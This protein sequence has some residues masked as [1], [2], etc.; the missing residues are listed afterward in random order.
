MRANLGPRGPPRSNSCAKLGTPG[1]ALVV[2]DASAAIEIVL[3][4]PLAGPLLERI[5]AEDLHAPHLID[6]ERHG[7]DF[8]LTRMWALR[9]SITAYDAAYIALAEAL[10]APLLTLDEKLARSHGNHADVEVIR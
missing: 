5:S 10:E 9:K 4:L 2:L 8:L 7:H 1:G 6:I 3:T